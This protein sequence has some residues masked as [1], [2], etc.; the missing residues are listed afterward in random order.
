M[1]SILKYESLYMLNIIEG[2]DSLATV[3]QKYQQAKNVL[4][5]K[6]LK[7]F[8]E[9]NFDKWQAERKFDKNSKTDCMKAMLPKETRKLTK[10]REVYGLYN[11]EMYD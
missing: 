7:L 1:Y 4:S 6:K 5:K 2:F 3:Q 10:I 9:A 11:Y 8:E